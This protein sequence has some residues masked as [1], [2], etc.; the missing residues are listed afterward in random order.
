MPRGGHVDATDARR[1]PPAQPGTVLAGDEFIPPQP[2]PALRRLDFLVHRWERAFDLDGKLV[3]DT[4]YEFY[5]YIPETGAYRT[6]FFTNLG[7]YDDAGSKYLG[8]FDGPALVLT[9]PVRTTRRPNPD[10][11]ISQQTDLPTGPGQWAPW[12]HT[13]LH[14]ID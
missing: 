5:D 11:T 3:P 14:R 4:G 8:G 10:G 13:R 1:P 12:L 7:G 2:D 9:G 6:H